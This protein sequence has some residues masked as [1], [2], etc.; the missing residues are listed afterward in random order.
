MGELL[1][2]LKR[3]RAELADEIEAASRQGGMALMAAV[4]RA[5]DALNDALVEA[6]D[7]ETA[8]CAEKHASLDEMRA[9]VSPGYS[10]VGCPD[11]GPD[12][13]MD[14]GGVE[15]DGA[16][17]RQEVTCLECDRAWV[18][19]YRFGGREQIE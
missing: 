7:E 2:K 11:C 12:A 10:G 18:N 6:G 15:I 3:I 5:R 14:G 8:R 4:V 1:V 9:M 17:A 13:D 16:L 19:E